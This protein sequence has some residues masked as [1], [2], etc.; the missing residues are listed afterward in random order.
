MTKNKG[1]NWN[2][3]HFSEL[4]ALE[5]YALSKIRMEVFIIEQ[6]CHYLDLDDNDLDAYHIYAT[7]DDQVIAYARLLA[8]GVSYPQVSI[9]R[10]L[11]AESARG[12]NLGHQLMN[13]TIQ[14]SNTVFDPNDIKIS[15]Q[16]HLTKFYEEHQFKVI[17]EMYL[18]DDIPH[19]GML[20]EV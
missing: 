14:F 19:V 16:Q 11:V 18:E 17:T 4:S 7:E 2:F 8:K 20:L 1:I 6:D 9:G 13:E 12:R 5:W 10:V 15:A 3:K